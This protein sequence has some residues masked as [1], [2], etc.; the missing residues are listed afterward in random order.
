MNKVIAHQTPYI[1][2]DRSAFFTSLALLILVS[3]YSYFSIHRSQA[4]G[5]KTQPVAA[6]V[7]AAPTG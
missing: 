1:P 7:L 4:A 2:T 5:A 6:I 3:V